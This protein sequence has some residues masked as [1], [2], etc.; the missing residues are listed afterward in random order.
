MPNV[1][2]RENEPFEFALHDSPGLAPFP[3]KAAF[4]PQFAAQP[5]SGRR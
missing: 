2:V 4:A 3:Q 1:K 5:V